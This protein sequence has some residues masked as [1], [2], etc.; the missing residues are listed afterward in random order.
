MTIKVE[1]LFDTLAEAVEFFARVRPLDT[2]PRPFEHAPLHLEAPS[3]Q[4]AAVVEPEEQAM[5]VEPEK[6]KKTRKVTISTGK[7]L[8]ALTRLATPKAEVVEI[9]TLEGVRA[10]LSKL[11]ASKG[12]DSCTAIL[13]KYQVS[14]IS[15]LDPELYGKFIAE[16]MS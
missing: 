14:R 5:V 11:L 16:C 15:E 3:V 8:E 7:T 4:P 12:V 13:A 1:L 10:A 6:P 2:E 9:S